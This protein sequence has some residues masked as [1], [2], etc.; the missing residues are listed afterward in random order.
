[1]NDIVSYG[2]I[3]TNIPNSVVSGNSIRPASVI[4]P[5]PLLKINFSDDIIIRDNYLNNGDYNISVLDSLRVKLIDNILASAQ[6]GEY[7]VT[8]TNSFIINGRSKSIRISEAG[9]KGFPWD[10]ASWTVVKATTGQYTVTHNMNSTDYS[11]ATMLDNDVTNP[12]RHISVK[13]NLDT[14]DLYI[15]DNA[16][17]AID[18]DLLVTV[19]APIVIDDIN[20]IQ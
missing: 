20:N 17:A 11:V 15:D 13:R 9:N 16:G 14:F 18:D 12:G 19:N 10:V 8:G 7:E 1:G 5:D 3:L 6:T 4:P 2:M